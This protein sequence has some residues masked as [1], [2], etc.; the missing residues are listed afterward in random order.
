LALLLERHYTFPVI[1][2]YELALFVFRL[3][4]AGEVDGRRLRARPRVATR[5]DLYAARDGLLKRGTFKEDKTLPGTVHRIMDRSRSDPESVL[6]AID[7]FGFV[8]HLSAMAFHGLSNRLPRVI[9]FTTLAASVWRSAAQEKMRKDLGDQL[10][11]YAEHGL[12]SLHRIQPERVQ[13]MVVSYVR[14][15]SHG[16]Y[17]IAREGTL[18]VATLGR[19][20][21]DMLRRPELCGGMSHV[22]EVYESRGR[23]HAM[24]IISELEQRGSPIDRVRAGYI[25]EERCGVTDPRLDA[26]VDDAQRGGSRKL[27]PQSEYAPR[28][29]ERWQLSINV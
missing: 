19:T 4:Q 29:S 3:L 27:D 6:S 20:F 26:W 22:L 24:L 17:R 12:P 13:G 28:F 14:S 16:G 10:H 5:S 2:N 11:L 1:T 23:E 21:L 25:L 7:P 9:V 8:S 18:R 15:S